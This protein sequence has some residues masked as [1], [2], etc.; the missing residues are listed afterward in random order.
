GGHL[1]GEA[2]GQL[3]V[4]GDPHPVQQVLHV[5][6]GDALRCV[7]LGGDPAVQQGGG[8]HVG[9]RVVG[10]L[11]GA[12]GALVALLAAADDGEG[13]VEGAQPDLLDRACGEAVLGVDV[14][15]GVQGR[16]GVDL[17]VVL[18]DDGAPDPLQVLGGPVD[19]EVA[20]DA[21]LEALVAL[22]DLFGAGDAAG[23]EQRGEQ[24][25]LGGVGVGQP[26]PVAEAAGAGDAE[27]V[28]GGAGDR[29]GVGDLA[30]GEA[31]RLGGGRRGGVGALGGVVEA[32]RAHRCDVGEAGVHL[33]GDGQGGEE[34][35]AGGVGRLGGGEHRAEV[36]G[37]VVGL[38]FGQVGVH[39]VEVAAER[40]VDE[41][42]A[43]GG[44]A[45]AADQG[46][47]GCAAQVA[48][49][50]AD[51]GHRGGVQRADRDAEGVQDPDGELFAGFGAHLRVVGPDDEFGEPLHF[52]H[53]LP[54]SLRVRTD[55]TY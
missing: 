49:E 9:Q 31:E 55:G 50:A 8:E 21:V 43:V 3:R 36:V 28:V 39:E 25:F 7:L 35:R 17:G 40:A 12:D 30:G 32:L 13:D 44:G 53:V 6:G 54:P 14:E 41:G 46:G 10:L 34:L 45:A 1:V 5:V 51:G 18:L 23:G 26:L 24:P 27:R 48:D 2:R 37:G 29:D 16:P 52:G 19:G 22:E 11:L 42:G 4:G 38:A 15:R 47:R 33:V 20:G